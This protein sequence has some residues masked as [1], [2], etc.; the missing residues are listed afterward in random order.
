M[1]ACSCTQVSLMDW[2]KSK[3]EWVG[4]VLPMD[5]QNNSRA[6]RET[7]LNAKSILP[8]RR[9]KTMLRLW[10]SGYLHTKTRDFAS[11]PHGEFAFFRNIK[12]ETVQRAL[13]G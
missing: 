4:V 10:Q 7:R 5:R 2:A 12:K 6:I 9:G 3:S 1:S 8:K 13:P 11:S